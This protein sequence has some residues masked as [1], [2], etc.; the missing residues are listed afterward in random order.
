MSAAL[1]ALGF[2]YDEAAMWGFMSPQEAYP[3]ATA[4]V[5]RALAIDDTLPDSHLAYGLVLHEYDWDWAGAE[6]EY[7]RA[8]ELDPKSAAGHQVYAEFLT[9]AGRKGQEADPEFSR[10]ASTVCFVYLQSRE[11][12]KAIKQC[13]EIV[14][15][16]PQ[17][18][19]G[20]ALL[21]NAF[22]YV[23]R[24]RDAE[25]EFQKALELSNNSASLLA[26]LG[27]TYALEGK[28]AEARGILAEMKTRS[29]QS[30]VSPVGAADIYL[31]LG[32]REQAF[33]MLQQAMQVRS[34]DLMFL[35]N[36]PEF[37]SLHGDPRFTAMVSKIGFPATAVSVP[38]RHSFSK[39]R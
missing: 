19:P 35:A 4:A 5:Q 21:A 15:L 12:E 2:S 27:M 13:S 16:D 22:V 7:R 25:V 18:M 3:K 38:A 10:T 14:E 37:D 29:G 31:G 30:Y 34:A 6:A 28:A 17:F 20:H 32:E 8:L 9:Y 1:A 33:A 24:Y 26:G 39:A 36:A 23:R 11:F